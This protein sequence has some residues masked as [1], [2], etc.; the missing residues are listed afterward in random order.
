MAS[1]SLSCSISKV[2]IFPPNGRSCMP[3]GPPPPDPGRDGAPADD[4]AR[5]DRARGWDPEEAEGWRPVPCRADWP[6]DPAEPEAWQ[7][8]QPPPDPEHDPGWFPDPADPALPYEVDPDALRAESRRI[9]AEQAAED[10]AEPAQTAGMAAAAA[11]DRRGPGMPGSARRIRGIYD[12]PAG[13]GFGSGQPLDLAPGGAALLGFAEAAA[14]DDDRFAGACDD[15]LAGIISA[16]DRVE[17]SA[18]SLKHAALAE[19]V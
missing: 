3:P 4:G 6:Q 12:S 9:A 1:Y 14:G 16:L 18:C 5:D 17:A 10:A 19:L 13:G 11:A 8:E 7:G 2:T 15:E